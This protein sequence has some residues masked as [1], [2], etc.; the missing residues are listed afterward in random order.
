[1][2]ALLTAVV[3]QDPAGGWMAYAVGQLPSEH[4]RITRLEMTW[5]V[6]KEPRHSRA[7][8]SPWFGT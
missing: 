5:T 8:F 7:F 1:M 2:L 4:E 6:G 3:S